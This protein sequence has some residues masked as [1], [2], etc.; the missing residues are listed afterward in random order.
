MVELLYGYHPSSWRK[1]YGVEAA[2][3]AMLWAE[4]ERGVRR[5]VAESEKVNLG[6]QK[7]LRKMEFKERVSSISNLNSYISER[8]KP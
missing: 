6:S 8:L 7:I 2:R 4:K 3:A 1:G 5:F